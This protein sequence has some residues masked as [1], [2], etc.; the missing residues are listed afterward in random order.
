[1]QQI[2]YFCLPM[3]KPTL[4]YYIMVIGGALEKS[5]FLKEKSCHANRTCHQEMKIYTSVEHTGDTDKI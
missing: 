3:S 5:C 4:K 2:L 1:M